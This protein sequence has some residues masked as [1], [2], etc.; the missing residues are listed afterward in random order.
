MSHCI[1]DSSHGRNTTHQKK[2]VAG[3]HMKNGALEKE[4]YSAWRGRAL[5]LERKGSGKQLSCKQSMG[6]RQ[7]SDKC[8]W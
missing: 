5:W 4:C 8:S 2:N 6:K 7:L 1:G 3:S